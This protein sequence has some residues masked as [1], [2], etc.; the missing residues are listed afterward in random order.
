MTGSKAV[1][2]DEYASHI[3]DVANK[4]EVQKIYFS[5][6]LPAR[7]ESARVPQHGVFGD[8]FSSPLGGG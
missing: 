7:L 3:V 5:I 8:S 4:I 6:A 2:A 1:E